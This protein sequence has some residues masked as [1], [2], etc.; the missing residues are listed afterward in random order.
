MKYV[1]KYMYSDEKFDHFESTYRET[2]LDSLTGENP[3]ADAVDAMITGSDGES[4]GSRGAAMAAKMKKFNPFQILKRGLGMFIDGSVDLISGTFGWD[5]KTVR[6]FVAVATVMA[7]P[8]ALG[9]CLLSFGGVF[10]KLL[11]SQE[12][13]RYGGVSDLTAIEKEEEDIVEADEDDD[14]D[15]D[16]D[17]GNDDSDQQ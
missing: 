11:Q 16:G 6:V 4:A 2:H 1:E 5:A 9:Y 3:V 8:P 17:G 13:R 12:K 7:F 10:R 14:D 15:D